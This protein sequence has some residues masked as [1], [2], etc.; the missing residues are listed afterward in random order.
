M[1]ATLSR[2]RMLSTFFLFISLMEPKNVNFAGDETKVSRTRD[3]LV[4]NRLLD[5]GQGKTVVTATTIR[6]TF[7]Q[8]LLLL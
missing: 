4:K 6:G 8:M 3:A 5:L 7:H 1:I 2:V